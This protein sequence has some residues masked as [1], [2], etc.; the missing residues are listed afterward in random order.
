MDIEKINTE[1]FNVTNGVR[2]QYNL[3]IF[4]PSRSLARAGLLH[5]N[6]VVTKNSNRITH[7]NHFDSHLRNPIL[8]IQYCGGS[9]YNLY[10]ENIAFAPLTGENTIRYKNRLFGFLKKPLPY[11]IITPTEYSKFVVDGWMASPA[12]RENILWE[13]FTHL[14]IGTVLTKEKISGIAIPYCVVTQNFGS[15]I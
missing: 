6:W 7:T 11:Q 13:S 5:S 8:R 2:Q 4:S 12:H 3:P 14:G 10:G 1:I 9:K 15:T